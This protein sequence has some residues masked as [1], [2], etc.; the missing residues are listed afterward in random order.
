MSALAC[1][2]V[3]LSVVSDSSQP[4][5]LSRIRL[6]CAWGCAGRNTGA[7]C[8]FLLQGFVC[9]CVCV[10][11]CSAVH[12]CLVF[13]TPWTVASQAPLPMEF[14]REESWIVLP[15]PTPGD[16]PD[17]GIQR[18]QANSLT[19][20]PPGKPLEVMQMNKN[21]PCHKGASLPSA[22]MENKQT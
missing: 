21:H 5:G 14:S 2:L 7:D 3:C 10:C 4:R 8:R 6:L 20:A 12:S 17:P 9:V 13:T 16:L 19:L 11:V 18:W 15:F 22:S 1:T